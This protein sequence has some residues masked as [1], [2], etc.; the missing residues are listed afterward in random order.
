MSVGDPFARVDSEA[1]GE[2][3]LEREC[4]SN[5]GWKQQRWVGGETIEEDTDPNHAPTGEIGVAERAAQRGSTVRLVHDWRVDAF[6]QQPLADGA[7][8]LHLATE[9]P[10]IRGIGGREMGVDPFEGEKRVGCQPAGQRDC[11]VRRGTEPV[12]AGIDLEVDT[13]WATERAGGRADCLDVGQRADRQGYVSCD[14]CAQACMVGG[15][16]HD[17]GSSETGLPKEQTFLDARDA[18]PACASRQRSE[19][20]GDE[21]VAVGIRLEDGEELD[22]GREKAD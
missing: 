2:P 16:Q 9:C 5:A 10:A 19:R 12:H 14:R 21:S 15:A 17:D 18:E 6:G 20:A 13:G 11:F 1:A 4:W 3:G 22:I 8:A 7:E